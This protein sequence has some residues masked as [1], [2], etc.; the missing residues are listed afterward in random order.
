MKTKPAL[1]R[2]THHYSFRCGEWAKITGVVVVEH[3]CHPPRAAFA[4]EYID[5][6][7]D[8]I[9]VCDHENYE[10]SDRATP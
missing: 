9:A 1:I 6:K 10:I 5:G 3:E 2:G 7:T 4:I 8:Y